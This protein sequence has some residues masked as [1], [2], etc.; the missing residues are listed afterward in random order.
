MKA[1]QTGFTIVEVLITIAFLGLSIV[2]ISNIFLG[3]QTIQRNAAY[4]DIAT[5]AAQRQIESLR[6]N[7]YSSLTPGQT[8]TFTNDIPATLPSRTGIA[9]VS[10]P[11]PDIRRIDAT[12]TYK[13]NNNTRTITISSLIGAIGLTK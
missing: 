13:I 2:G 9:V 1:N 8:I 11:S 5:R 3:V 6:S 4:T 7:N 12:V 10:E